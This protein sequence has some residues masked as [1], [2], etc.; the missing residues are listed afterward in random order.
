MMPQREANESTYEQAGANY[1]RY[2]GGQADTRQYYDTSYEQPL[3]EGPGAGGKVYPEPHDS[4]NMFRLGIF[5]ISMVTLLI[6]AFLF[7]FFL[8]GTGGWI[9]FV[10]AA[11]VIF[12]IAVVTVDKIK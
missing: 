5:L 1:G 7:I 11:F 10:V 2:E 6:C 8:G 12:L 4:K 9:S 3:R